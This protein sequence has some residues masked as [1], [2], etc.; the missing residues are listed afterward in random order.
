MTSGLDNN[1]TQ[2]LFKFLCENP[3][4]GTEEEIFRNWVCQLAE[5]PPPDSLPICFQ[6]I[7]NMQRSK[8]SKDLLKKYGKLFY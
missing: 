8:V 5:V 1:I 3:T 6:M 7:R 2:N 4:S